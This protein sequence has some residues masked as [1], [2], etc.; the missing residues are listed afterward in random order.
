MTGAI[1]LSA[2][3]KDMNGEAFSDLSETI[4]VGRHTATVTGLAGWR[5]ADGEIDFD[6]AST[7]RYAEVQDR[8]VLADRADR[9]AELRRI[10]K[11]LRL[12][13]QQAAALT[14]GGKNAFNRYETGLAQPVAAV[15]HLFFLLDR[16]PELLNELPLR[17]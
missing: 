9:G 10:R 14:G 4:T 15:D 2:R 13:Q 7:A 3:D 17:A 1:F 16:H 11:K 12:T 8:L 6:D 5:H